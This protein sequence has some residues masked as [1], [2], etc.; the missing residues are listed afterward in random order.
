MILFIIVRPITPRRPLRPLL[1]LSVFGFAGSQL[2]YLGAIQFS[3]AATATLLQF[4]FLPIV[5]GYEAVKGVLR[6]S[7]QWSVSLLLAM[8]GTLVLG[9]GVPGWSFRILVTSDGVWV[10]LLAAVS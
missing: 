8:V 7:V 5:A 2:A 3:N 6:W 10:R 9:G 1:G 4:L